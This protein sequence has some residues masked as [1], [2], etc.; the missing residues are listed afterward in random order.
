MMVFQA[1]VGCFGVGTPDVTNPTQI[2]AMY[3]MID[4]AIEY[5][6]ILGN[7]ITNLNCFCSHE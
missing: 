7:T 5:G 3:P 2:E 4:A 6:G 1:V